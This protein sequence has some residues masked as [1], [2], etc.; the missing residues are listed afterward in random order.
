MLLDASILVIYDD[1]MRFT[2][3]A[4]P[5][6][7]AGLATPAG[8]A[9]SPMEDGTGRADDLGFVHSRSSVPVAAMPASGREAPSKTIA[10]EP[11]TR[12]QPVLG[13]DAEPPDRRPSRVTRVR[14]CAANRAALAFLPDLA[15]ELNGLLS[16]C[17]TA[18]PPPSS[19]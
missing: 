11:R 14:M 12:H 17:T 1:L 18:C 5:L 8:A 6:L 19:R 7:L 15:R 9:P 10:G 16:A 13:Q 4:L 3:I 2:W